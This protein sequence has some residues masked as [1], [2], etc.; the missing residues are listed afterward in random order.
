MQ[1]R[2]DAA[3]TRCAHRICYYLLF[4]T[5]I[6]WFGLMLLAAS[7]LN[8]L[9]EQKAIRSIERWLYTS[10]PEEISEARKTYRGMKRT[11]MHPM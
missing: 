2:I 7:K 11:G 3:I 10:S 9:I 4:E 8:K 6:G 5:I 1:N